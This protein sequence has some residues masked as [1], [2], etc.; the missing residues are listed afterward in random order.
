MQARLAIDA[1]Q[2]LLAQHRVHEAIA[3][4]TTAAGEGDVDAVFQLTMWRLAGSPLSRDLQLARQL[5][6]QAAGMGHIDAAMIEIA[7]TANGSGGLPDWHEAVSLLKSVAKHDDAARAHLTLIAHHP[8]KNDG[9]P[10]TPTRGEPLTADQRIVRFSDFLTPAECELIARTAAPRLEPAM[11][12]DS[13][14][15]RSQPHQ[16]RTSDATVI[17]PTIENL[18][19]RA[20]NLRIAAATGTDVR[21]GEALTILRYRP[22]QEYKPH[23]DALGRTSNDRMMTLLI[24]LNE[25]FVGGDTCFPLYDLKVRPRAGEAIAFYNLR[26]DGTADKRMQHAGAP[27]VQGV[28]WVATR[29]I[30]A[31]PFDV[32]TGPNAI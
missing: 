4:V 29:W 28:K 6:R 19:I 26:D 22:G 27:V 12:V 16:V 23:L 21:Q 17:S 8:L 1:V 20:I 9:A 3:L 14:T 24:Y 13:E 7:L 10:V 5:L 32:W 11:I 18:V 15:G 25:G 2:T 30:R 31:R